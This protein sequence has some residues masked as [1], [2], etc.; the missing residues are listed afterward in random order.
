MIPVDLYLLFVLVSLVVMIS[1]GPAVV[2]AITNGMLHGSRGACAA[3][4][5]NMTGFAILSSV[6]VA[7]LG[8][9]IAA[10]GWLFDLLKWMGGLYLIYLGVMMWLSQRQRVGVNAQIESVKSLHGFQLY[11]RGLA[12]T[13]SNPKAFV[14]VTA[15]LP[16]FIDTGKPVLPQFLILI[17]TMMTLQMIVLNAYAFLSGRVRDWLNAPGRMSLFNKII[18]STF[19]GFGVS[20]LFTNQNS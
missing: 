13:L 16:Q 5:G 15:L 2:L 6:S 20:L 11:K 9:L 1:P 17:L 3:V 7:G 19:I 8:A 12:V 4:F 14:F 18:G 10:N